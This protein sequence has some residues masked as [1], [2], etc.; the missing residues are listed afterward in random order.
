MGVQIWVI[1]YGSGVT[2][3]ASLQGCASDTTKASQAAD[4]TAL[5]AKFQEIGKDIGALRL[6]K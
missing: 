1:G 2:M 3:D 4:T 6:T 5:I